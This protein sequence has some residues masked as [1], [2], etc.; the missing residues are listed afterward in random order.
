MLVKLVNMPIFATTSLL[1][2][3]FSYQRTPLHLAAREGCDYTVTCLVQKG[4]DINIKD[5]DG[6][7]ETI[8]LMVVYWPTADLRLST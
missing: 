3:T 2:V 6:V 8:F 7:R 1:F 5:K 4:A